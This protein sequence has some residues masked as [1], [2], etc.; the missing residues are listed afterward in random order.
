[1]ECKGPE[2]ADRAAR[3]PPGMRYGWDESFRSMAEK[4]D[5]ALLDDS[6]PTDWDEVEWEWG[7][8]HRSR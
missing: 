1:M 8:A 3:T 5:D 7:G 4:G 2:K 6:V